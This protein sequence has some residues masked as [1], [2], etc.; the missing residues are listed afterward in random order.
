MQKLINHNKLKAIGSFIIILILLMI[1]VIWTL[2]TRPSIGAYG[3]DF[4]RKVIGNQ[5]VVRLETLLFTL[6]DHLQQIEYRV[7][8]KKPVN[9]WSATDESYP[10]SSLST[11]QAED[12][13]VN[14]PPTGILTQVI[15][16][17][18]RPGNP[19]LTQIPAVEITRGITSTQEQSSGTVTPN[20][21]LHENN[22]DPNSTDPSA[23]HCLINKSQAGDIS[24]WLLPTIQPSG[25]VEGEGIWQPYLLNKYQRVVAYRTFVV[26]DPQRPYVLVAIVA[27][28]MEYTRL[29][30]VIG[31]QD[32][33][34][35]EIIQ[36]TKGSIAPIHLKSGILLAAFNGGFKYEHGKFGS[37]A[38]GLVS[39]HPRDN[40]ATLAIYQ[41]GRIQ[42][43]AWGH[44]I[45][46][47]DDLVAFRQDGPLVI[48][49]GEVAT[50][51][52]DSKY[53]GFTLTGG[54]VTW[55]SGL[56][57]DSL[58]KTLYYFAGPDLSI[59]TLANA[60]STV[61]PH[62]AMQLDINNYWVHFVKIL[63]Q[64]DQL[65]AEPL[66][67]GKVMS[68]RVDRYLWPYSRDFFYITSWDH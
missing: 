63:A 29:H 54:T 20:P 62:M 15:P 59:Q 30:Y 12:G 56:A 36:R 1:G 53:W 66:F 61:R 32:P 22:C 23:Q 27:F 26:P 64:A 34:D 51:V 19:S 65:I 25:N 5:A 17:E 58:G 3:A 18:D 4:L 24:A 40:L 52:N 21:P 48:Q 28:D 68:D 49:N 13:R 44:E 10:A 16:T 41:D 2:S 14:Q 33:Y 60:M 45:M 43:G 37:M 6:Q 57:T 47:S 46:P 11:S 39:V 7:G 55:R 31:F 42:I 67:P 38:D 8:L 50:Q 35:P 9:P